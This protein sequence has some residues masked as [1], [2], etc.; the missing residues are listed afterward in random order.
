M[1]RLNFRHTVAACCIGYVTE[2][3]IV[4][5]APLLFLTFSREY[6]IP[7]GRMTFIIMMNFGTQLIVDF[8]AAGF[9][10]R[11]G[12]RRTALI[13]HGLAS[14]GL[15][16]LAVLPDLLPSPF[17]GILI[18]TLVYA[19]G[20][21][22]LEVIVSPIVEACPTGNKASAMNFLHSFYSWGTAGVILISTLFL[23]L[24]GG[25]KWRL[26]A[27]IWSILPI[28]NAFFFSAVPINAPTAEDS[29]HGSIKGL[30]KSG[31]FWVFIV[32]M[33]CAG[34]AEQCVSQRASAFAESGLGVSKAVGDLAGPCMFA[35]FMAVAR[36]LG[37]KLGNGKRLVPSLMICSL[38]CIGAYCLT[39]IP[40]SPVLSLIGCG[41]C[42]FSVGIFWPS[43]Y[44]LGTAKVRGETAMFAFFALAGD[45]GCVFGPALTGLV[46]GRSGEGLK[47]GLALGMIFPAIM[48]ILLA[49]LSQKEKKR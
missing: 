17:A 38:L 13:A 36:M 30:A 47:S 24:F 28:L 31:M 3:V 18:S 44:S 11:I 1:K 16:L 15:I 9:V 19:V 7:L 22:L 40:T 27:L 48:M 45:F 35:V 46:S 12:Y 41:L 25:E 42:G 23:N 6:G 29:A 43:V 4:N 49:S 37:A 2:A 14:A 10:D 39:V 5:Y 32:L 34:A 20:C 8:L 26:L 33:L 21:G